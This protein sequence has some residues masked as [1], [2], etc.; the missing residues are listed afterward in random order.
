MAL[1]CDPLVGP[2]QLISYGAEPPEIVKSIAP[3]PSPLQVI[4]V[5][6]LVWDTA[7]ALVM[8]KDSLSVQP[9]AS[10]IVTE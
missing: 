4:C 6:E 9:L 5:L 2:V 7:T 10:V 8:V 3:S 1:F